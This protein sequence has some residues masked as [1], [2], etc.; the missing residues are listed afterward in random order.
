MIY[1]L[2]TFLAS[3]IPS[4][5]PPPEGLFYYVL[6][7]ALASIL[8]A[9]IGYFAVMTHK[10]LKELVESK[11]EHHTRLV[12]LENESMRINK[13]LDSIDSGYRDNPKVKYKNR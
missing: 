13:K 2:I 10:L 4:P 5:K 6:S 1:R 7:G 9:V 3:E 8:I 12:V 11:N